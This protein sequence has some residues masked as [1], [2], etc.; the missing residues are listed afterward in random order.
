VTDDEKLSDFCD[1]VASKMAA[2]ILGM[3]P[4]GKVGASIETMLSG[5]LTIYCSGRRLRMP[6]RAVEAWICVAQRE[7][8]VLIHQQ[9]VE[10]N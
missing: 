4:E 7:L 1:Q 6:P 8:E 3:T 2:S 5:A 10:A 9:I